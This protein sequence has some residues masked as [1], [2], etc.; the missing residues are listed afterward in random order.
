MNRH[1]ANPLAALTGCLLLL[2]APAAS[3]LD[4]RW[5]VSFS[6]DGHLPSLNHLDDGLYQAPFMG[7]AT[8]LVQEG[9]AGGELI[10]G[11]DANETELIPFTFNNPIGPVRF[12]PRGGVEF[13]WHAND[14]HA[15]L[16]GFGSM[17]HV[18]TNQ[19]TGNI[20]VQQFFVSNV[21]EGVR[22]GKISYNEYSLG[23]RYT[24]V[25][26]DRFRFYSKVTV[27]E[28]FDISYREEWTFLFTDSPIDELIGVRR[29]MVT[30]AKST[31]LFMGQVGVGV[32]VFLTDWMSIGMEG[33]YILGER[34]FSLREVDL[35]DDFTAGDALSRTGLPFREM[36]DGTLGFMNPGTTVDELANPGT[37]DDF[38]TPIR[39]GF[40]GWRA[41]I[42]FNLYF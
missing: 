29:N 27:H 9:S 31:S 19:S 25:N 16:F 30:E 3:A 40:D 13:A 24:M 41:G 38:Y 35:R 1:A 17:E 18:A 34:E 23:W 26:R 36:P 4:E 14:R 2:A 15:F 12:A 8:V 5:S 21:V 32:E 39:I 10:D 20:P 11:E 28:V 33:G 37:R 22:R 42:R 6:L 7:T